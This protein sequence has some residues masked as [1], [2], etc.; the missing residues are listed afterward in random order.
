MFD[1]IGMMANSHW[2][3]AWKTSSL[4]LTTNSLG[5]VLGFNLSFHRT[6]C[7]PWH[8]CC[9]RI[10]ASVASCPTSHT[11]NQQMSILE[12]I[13]AMRKSWVGH[14]STATANLIG[15]KTWPNRWD[16][17][18]IFGE[19]VILR[20]NIDK[21]IVGT[22]RT[23][24]TIGLCLRSYMYNMCVYHNIDLSAMLSDKCFGH[25]GTVGLKVLRTLFWVNSFGGRG[26]V[27]NKKA[28]TKRCPWMPMSIKEPI[29]CCSTSTSHPVFAGCQHLF[30]RLPFARLWSNKT[31]Q[32]GAF[33]SF[34]CLVNGKG[35]RCQKSSWRG[36][37]SHDSVTQRAD[38]F[39]SGE[40]LPVA[41]AIPSENPWLLAKQEAQM[42]PRY[43]QGMGF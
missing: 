15:L 26:W 6:I 31:W 28:E 2:I 36:K 42:Q 8:R 22:E 1:H 30:G 32:T 7:V 21:F 38:R 18:L 14:S 27:R 43:V 35:G 17:W 39:K 10:G 24:L 25:G 19:C 16:W 34:G 9:V 11:S 12:R 5:M 23:I 41:P 20:F 13:G 37:M 29:K 3:A 40:M 33:A 4:I